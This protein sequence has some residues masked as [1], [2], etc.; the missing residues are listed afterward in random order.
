MYYDDEARRFNF[1]SGLLLG[2]V[3]GTG[4]ALASAPRLR[5]RSRARPLEASVGALRK[6]A[7]RARA[8]LEEGW[9]DAIAGLRA[10]LRR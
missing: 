8:G 3:L 10:G 7:G 1:L 4:L 6:G 9:E 5:P 2:A